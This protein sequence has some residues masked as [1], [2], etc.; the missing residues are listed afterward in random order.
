MTMPTDPVVRPVPEPMNRPIRLGVLISGGGTTL[1]NLLQHIESGALEAEVVSVLASRADCRGIER[2]NAAGI[3]TDVIA[4]K[5][6]DSSESMSDA[7]FASLRTSDVDLVILGGYLSR[8]TIPEDFRWRVLNIH[9]SLI[10]AFSGPG[11]YGHHVHDAALER[12]VKISGC[13]VHFADDQYDHG[14][15]I[16]QR[17][18][19]VLDDDTPD[20]L[21][22][23]V[24][25]AECKAFP[26]AIRLYAEGLL[27]ISG[28]RVRILD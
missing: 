8:V 27:E 6:F 19:A 22:A 21:A 3:P 25:D 16:L 20:S 17:P 12:G 13:T 24:F 2:A 14:P 5:E 9:P 15:I 7:L 28:H 11:F 4:R 1:L 26:E 18:V 10:P 23:R